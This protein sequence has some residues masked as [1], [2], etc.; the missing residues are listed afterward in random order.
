MRRLLSAAVLSLAISAVSFP[1]LAADAPKADAKQTD[2]PVKAVVLFSSG[3][4]YFEH[5]GQ[6]KGIKGQRLAF[7]SRDA[8]HVGDRL[9]AQPKTDMAGQAW[10]VREIFVNNKK[11]EVPESDI[12]RKKRMGSYQYVGGTIRNCFDDIF[13]LMRGCKP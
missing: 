6:I 9:R 12:F 10:T 5:V 8:L 2:V 7:D 13:I 3:V 4:G 11:T 1:C